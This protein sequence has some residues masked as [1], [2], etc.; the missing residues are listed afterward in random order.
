MKKIYMILAAALVMSAANSCDKANVSQDNFS[1]E[2][3]V[4]NF[5]AKVA[6]TKTVFKP[7]SLVN[8]A[9]VPVL[10][11]GNEGID[12]YVNE[13]TLTGLV[14]EIPVQIEGEVPSATA[15]WSYDFSKTYNGTFSDGY[16][17]KAPFTFYAF[18]PGKNTRAFFNAGKQRILVDGIPAEQTPGENSCDEAAMMVCSISQE[19]DLWPEDVEM[20]PFK[21]M[22]AYGCI[23][24]GSGAPTEGIKKVSVT[25][26]A[27]QY[28]AGAAWYYYAGDQ[29]GEW[30]NYSNLGTETININTES[31]EN[32]WFGCRPTTA[33]T[34]L[35]F[36]VVTEA[37][38]TYKVVKDLTGKNLNFTAGKV[39]IMTIDG[40]E[41]VEDESVAETLTYV[42]EASA[43]GSGFILGEFAQ[44]G[45]EGL[46]WNNSTASQTFD[47]GEPSL[48]WTVETTSSIYSVLDGV[49]GSTQRLKI[50]ANINPF[51]F[52]INTGSSYKVKKV[53]VYASAANSGCRQITIKVGEEILV[54][55]SSLPASMTFS[56]IE[57]GGELSEAVQGDVS[58]DISTIEGK[59]A[60]ITY[61][62][63]VELTME[64][65]SSQE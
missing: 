8:G 6:D 14:P 51:K 10:W 18:C 29:E 25:A 53:R 62:Y 7:V 39:V 30:E 5:T 42:W 63:K 57:F 61:L 37:G 46:T 11:T 59:T 28:L 54:P 27:G 48:K 2:P 58:V 21:H 19:Y 16:V 47:Y 64:K 50:A 36:E 17:P 32:I 45:G 34:S 40:F 49:K 38:E 13:E 55:A 56:E 22:T 33:L 20:P 44:G 3:M 52:T 41:K 9:S 43:T 65:I 1:V 4:V 12:I 23:T 26:N 35:T 31:G 15:S 24:L 60:K